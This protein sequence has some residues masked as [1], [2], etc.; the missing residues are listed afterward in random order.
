MKDRIETKTDADLLSE[1]RRTHKSVQTRDIA[2]GNRG[3][4]HQAF[5]SVLLADSE[6]LVLVNVV[7]EGFGNFSNNI[8]L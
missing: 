2:Q 7:S 4:K 5:V 1:V 8:S 6:S 3:V